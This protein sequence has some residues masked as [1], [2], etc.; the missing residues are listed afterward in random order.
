MEGEAGL[1]M[2]SSHGL[3]GLPWRKRLCPLQVPML[4]SNPQDDGIRRWGL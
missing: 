1:S 4:R 3:W 2:A